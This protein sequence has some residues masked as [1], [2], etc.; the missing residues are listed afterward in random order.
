MSEAEDRKTLLLV[1]D[2]PANIQ[3]ANAILKDDYR[4][5]VAT[6]GAKALELVKAKAGAR[7]DPPRR[8]DAGDGRLRGLPAPEGGSR[9]PGDSGDL[10]DGK[11]RGR[12]RD[13]RLLRGSGGLHP[14][15]LLARRREGARADA[16][17]AA[18][19]ARAARAAA[20]GDPAR[21]RDGAEDP[22][23]D[24]A[25]R[26]AAHRGTRDRGAVRPDDVRRRGLL[27]FPP[28]G[29]EALRGPRGRRVGARRARRARRFDAEDRARRSGPARLGPGACPR[30]PE[31]GALRQ[32]RNP[33]RDRGLRLRR[34][35]EG[36]D[37]LRRRRA[38]SPRALREGGRERAGR[39]AE[40]SLPRHVPARQVLG[41]PG[42]R[43]LRATAARSTPTACRKPATG[44]ARN[45]GPTGS[46]PCSRR[47]WT[48]RR[49]PLPTGCSTL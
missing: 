37:R 13:P 9:D 47:P 28:G 43:S 24:P 34:H 33:L 40:R 15:A 39:P 17:R 7:P 27:R 5:R 46:R 32:V 41:S 36:D 14:Q 42:A 23:L 26:G 10:P 48:S 49:T 44:R 8:R 2:A 29:R 25:A 31:P 16:P 1:D 12:G 35:G 3:V 18:R 30:R 4:V 21:A 38:S 19:D 20:R 11:D 45:S 6:S 22:A